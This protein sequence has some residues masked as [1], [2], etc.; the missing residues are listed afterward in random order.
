M[1]NHERPR[2]DDST[3]DEIERIIADALSRSKEAGS[4]FDPRKFAQDG[5]HGL[6]YEDAVLE[7]K[8]TEVIGGSV[9]P[10]APTLQIAH[11]RGPEE[12]SK[13]DRKD[14]IPDIFHLPGPKVV[15]QEGERNKPVVSIKE[16]SIETKIQE[17]EFK[18]FIGIAE[19]CFKS[20]KGVD[21]NRAQELASHNNLTGLLEM[22]ERVEK[23]EL[24][25]ETVLNTMQVYV[26][27][28][29]EGEREKG[30]LQKV[31]FLKNDKYMQY[32][33]ERISR[34]KLEILNEVLKELIEKLEKKELEKQKK[35][36][37]EVKIFVIA[38]KIVNYNFG[39]ELQDRHLRL[40]KDD[41]KND[42][43]TL[44]VKGVVRKMLSDEGL[45]YDKDLPDAYTKIR[46]L[47]RNLNETS[48]I[49]FKFLL[50]LPEDKF[51]SWTVEELGNAWN[52]RILLRQIQEN[53]ALLDEF[54]LQ[55][56]DCAAKVYNKYVLYLRS[57]QEKKEKEARDKIKEEEGR[58]RKEREV[59]QL[60]EVERNRERVMRQ[61]NEWRERNAE[62]VRRRE[63][64]EHK[65]RSGEIAEEEGLFFE[66]RKVGMNNTAAEK[67]MQ[68]DLDF[69]R[70]L[71]R[72]DAEELRNQI[73]K[74]ETKRVKDDVVDKD[75][76]GEVARRAV[77]VAAKVQGPISISLRDGYAHE[78]MEISRKV[79]LENN[80]LLRESIIR[81]VFDTIQ[82][83][84][85]GG[86]LEI[87]LWS[88]DYQKQIIDLLI[89]ESILEIDNKNFKPMV[90]I[91]PGPD[92]EVE[93]I[94]DTKE[95]L[96][97]FINHFLANL[98]RIRILEK[99]YGTTLV[100]RKFKSK[101]K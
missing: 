12:V 67:Q 93:H 45:D 87:D 101:L 69:A 39:F 35:Q 6:H 85:D 17:Q 91:S 23:S 66:K 4:E 5:G 60:A 14:E 47:F 59:V 3:L 51:R 11:V 100:A 15:V 78:L 92:G 83:Q 68:A 64:A 82:Q 57:E 29:I 42:D 97:H 95:E 75:K 22:R 65:R 30:F 90:I 52:Q 62:I 41:R 27:T 50:T 20:M 33:Q 86:K 16:Q 71:Q 94:F 80:V 10:P 61:E 25:V 34:Y 8:A 81:P 44:K 26:K 48:E 73:K 36:E 84:V 88:E 55:V 9:P 13:K 21:S 53:E 70:L 98:I 89:K 40:K 28:G 18:K 58:K 38:E 72:E 1:L 7:L 79:K 46:E 74:V 99:V 24:T 43:E 96:L 31:A 77:A 19:G 56:Y 63:V 37:R 54:G 76:L 2:K 32:L 49:I